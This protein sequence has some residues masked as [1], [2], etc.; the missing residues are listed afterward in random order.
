MEFV[1]AE[2]TG[3]ER[4]LA[5]LGRAVAHALA[6]AA[7]P[8]HDP[9][10]ARA[11]LVQTL[12]AFGEI[13]EQAHQ[14]VLAAMARWVMA[15]QQ[16]QLD[17]GQGPAADELEALRKLVPALGALLR[18]PES[19][20][21]VEGVIALLDV[22]G[23]P[24]PAEVLRLTI[25]RD[26]L[27][28]GAADRPPPV[29]GNGSDPA[30]AAADLAGADA[31]QAP[32]DCAELLAE[33]GMAATALVGGEGPELAAYGDC[34]ELLE[35]IADRA[36]AQGAPALAP[37][38]LLLARNFTPE[39]APARLAD[40]SWLLPMLDLPTL[41]MPY[42]QEAPPD[43][44]A[45]EE[46]VRCL[47]DPSWPLP[48]EAADVRALVGGLAGTPA[49]GTP[50]VTAAPP[51][52]AGA[53]MRT[54]A[55]AADGDPPASAAAAAPVYSTADPE[56]LAMLAGE[57]AHLGVQL[58]AEI[59]GTGRADGGAA[60]Q[61]PDV[62]A[63]ADLLRRHADAAGSIGLPA[64]GGLLAHVA[65]RVRAQSAS[66]WRPAYS[67]VLLALAR[68]LVAYLAAPT[69]AASA[70][71][72]VG[73]V[74]DAGPWLAPRPGVAQEWTAALARVVLMRS[75]DVAAPRREELIPQD[76][77]LDLPDD[78]EPELLQGL[79][80]ELPMQCGT[81]TSAIH[82]VAA[83]HGTAQDLNAAKRAAHTLKGAA[84]TVGVRG[85]ARLTHDLEDILIALTAKRV[86]PSPALA[87]VLGRA[88]DCL[89]AMSDALLGEGEPPAD[90]VE[91]LQVVRTWADTV[92]RYEPA[93]DGNA[94]AGAWRSDGATAPA[95][96]AKAIEQ[97]APAA[98]PA[99]PPA[100]PQPP[101]ATL[102]V[103]ASVV[104]EL[105]RLVGETMIANSQIR[106]QLRLAREHAG[107][108]RRQ[109]QL[110][111]Q[112]AGELEH[113]VEIRGFA[114]PSG[115][116]QERS[117]FDAL[118]FERYGE[119]QMLTRRIVEAAADSH[120]LVEGNERRLGDLA[121]LIDAQGRFHVENQDAVMRARRVPVDTIVA[122]LQ[123]TVRQTCR[124]TGKAVELVVRG[125]AT[126]LDS[127]VLAELVDPLMHVLRNAVDHGIEDA[128]TRARRGKPDVG[129]IELEFAREGTAIRIRCADD[130]GGLDLAAIRAKA[131]KLGLIGADQAASDEAVGRLILASGLTTRETSSQVSGR[132]I[133]MDAVYGRI[134]ALKGTLRLANRPG[135]GLAIEMRLPATLMTTQGLL[136]RHGGRVLVASDYGVQDIRYVDP[137]SVSEL[138]AVTAFRDGDQLHELVPLADLLGEEAAAA[139]AAAGVTVLMVQLDD[140]SRRAVRVETV[141]ECREIVVKPLGRYVTRPA[142]VLG[143]TILGD[144]SMAPVLDLPRLVQTLSQE[145]GRPVVPRP[146]QEAPVAR[147]IALVVDDSLTAR[148]AAAR[149]ARSAGF[150][151]RTAPDGLDAMAL[152]DKERP[153]LVLVD[154]EM[155]RMNGLELTAR[156]RSRP[157]TRGVPIV[158][159]TSRSSPLHREQAQSA[160]VD[161]YLV[162]PFKEAALIE[163]ITHLCVTEAG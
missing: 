119:L 27:L 33:L 35:R 106:E 75:S 126:A 68:S 6:A 45:A 50:T 11:P 87:E 103:P 88:A 12:A 8:H 136:L 21:A 90:A 132:G 154:M 99:M 3:V 159:I 114:T 109:D 116:A 63:A 96:G 98:A 1:G 40:K 84:N 64:L 56:H 22:P 24:E 100:M 46:L 19:S 89:E 38:C 91:V 105:L 81:F 149:A 160:G 59:D 108:V 41:L 52:D 113:L 86:W 47:L 85:V 31:S 127:Q 70:A 60:D 42:F 9:A 151:V 66:Q 121:E 150:D 115:D 117:G 69:E 39:E 13:A 67:D 30:P 93:S 17:A 79:L 143:V 44:E 155:P 131:V 78:I 82:A 23:W 10:S 107:G 128:P 138:G 145:A 57:A 62:A 141:L 61:G 7:D 144:G 5:V 95:S 125:G 25:V 65:E 4:G 94:D 162:K 124:E 163:Q 133:G 16:H 28:Q 20:T 36:Q 97:A 58:L 18:E 148:T 110:L 14:H 139:D 51:G 137:A 92:E 48:I 129:R 118:E 15:N 111:Q 32:R 156:L 49:A 112:L 157:Q 83:G 152:V 123:R 55:A 130:G 74:V 102:R 71:G 73:V 54:A 29:A 76:V 140:G 53:P 153:D 134:S 43:A 80:T 161:A 142:G 122:R 101:Q 104:D 158:M 2:P 147:R 120:D 72:L 26:Q 37:L 34:R 77:S 135:Q 146:P